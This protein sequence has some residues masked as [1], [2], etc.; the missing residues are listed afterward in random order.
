MAG[1]GD[2]HNCGGPIWAIFEADAVARENWTTAPPH[3][4]TGHGFFFTADTLADLA[5][6][7]VMPHQRLPMLPENLD[8]TVA[9]YNT[10]VDSGTDEDFGKP[11]P[12]TTSPRHPSMPPG[13]PRRSTTRGVAC[14]SMAIA[15]W[16][17]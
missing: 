3:V 12:L 10:F 14:G 9:R 13:P 8:A 5:R 7:I 4:D 15:R 2:S 16:W 11:K 6:M 17:P 1:I